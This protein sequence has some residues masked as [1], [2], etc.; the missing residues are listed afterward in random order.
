MLCLS[1]PDP[2]AWRTWLRVIGFA[3][4]R[5][6]TH[7]LFVGNAPDPVPY[8]GDVSFKS[9]SFVQMY[10]VFREQCSQSFER[11]AESLENELNKRPYD[12]SAPNSLM[13]VLETSQADKQE[14]FSEREQTM[15][16]TLRTIALLV[17]RMQNEVASEPVYAP[18]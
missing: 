9:K 1:K 6:R 18:E 15:L 16:R 8:F 10:A 7:L 12:M 13:A 5:L 14:T 2:P 17:D 4:G 11:M 3:G